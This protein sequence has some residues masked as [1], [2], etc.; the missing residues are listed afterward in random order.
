MSSRCSAAFAGH[1]EERLHLKALVSGTKTVDTVML[2]YVDDLLGGG[3]RIDGYVVVATILQ[4][5]QAAVDAIEQ[6]IERQ[7]AVGHGSNGID[8]VGIA[9][10]HEVTKLLADTF[11]FLA[12]IVLWRKFGELFGSHFADTTEFLVSISIR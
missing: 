7:I 8:R 12:P 3:H 2:F 1:Q 5:N 10:T 9:A 6:Q 4:N 11:D